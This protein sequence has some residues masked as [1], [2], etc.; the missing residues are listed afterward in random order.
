MISF[1]PC[2][3]IITCISVLLLTLSPPVTAFDILSP[4]DSIYCKHYETQGTSLIRVQIVCS[5]RSA[6]E[7]MQQMYTVQNIFI[8]FSE[9]KVA[10]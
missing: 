10:G 5:V 7:F 2:I 3:I 4:L 8:A 9:Q 6:L 1:F